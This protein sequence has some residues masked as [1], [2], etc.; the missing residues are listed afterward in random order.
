MNKFQGSSPVEDPFFQMQN[1]NQNPIV[2]GPISPDQSESE[3]LTD[4]KD[5]DG[6]AK[7]VLFFCEQCHGPLAPIAQCCVCKK[8][9]HRQCTQCNF[10]MISEKHDSCKNLIIYS[11][12]SSKRLQDRNEEDT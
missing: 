8:A 4:F 2:P 12:F 1:P 6:L 10:Q 9:T 3:H 11:K 7:R 5:R